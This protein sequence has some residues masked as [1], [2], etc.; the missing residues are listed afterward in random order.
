MRITKLSLAGASLFILGAVAAHGAAAQDTAKSTPSTAKS[1][2]TVVVVTGSRVIK[3]GD[4]SPSPVTVLPTAD[5][6]KVEPGA[7]LADALNSLPVFAGSRSAASNPTSVGSAAGGN[8]DANQLNLR[9]LGANRTLVLMDGMRVP[10]TLQ[11]AVVDVDIIPQMLVS[12]VDVVT[13]GVSAVYGSDAMSGVVNYVVN[14]KFNGF[15]ADAS[16]GITQYGDDV[17]T[18]GG[19]AWGHKIGDKGHLELSYE[20]HKED[21]VPYRTDRPWFDQ[22]GV[23]GS[24]AGSTVAPGSSGNPFEVF[25]NL[26]QSTS[27]FGGMITSG[28]LKGQTFTQNGVLS[29]FVAGAAT[30][31]TGVQV[32][33]GGAYANPNLLGAL[34][35]NQFFSR[36]DYDFSN[37]IHG[38]AEIASDVKTNV[39]E[40][41]TNQLT[42]VTLFSNNA[43]LSPTYQTAMAGSSTFTLSEYL[44]DVPRQQATAH[45]NQLIFTT[46]LDGKFGGAA[47]KIDYSHGDS[48]LRTDLVNII[49]NQHLALA[50]D[51]VQNPSSPTGTPV[52]YSTTISPG[53][54]CVAFNPF[55]PT[56][57]S[58][59]AINYITDTLHIGAETKMDDVSAQVTGSPFSTWAGPVN[60]ALSAEWRKTSYT[61]FS[62]ILPTAVVDCTT[63]GLRNNC[64]TATSTKAGTALGSVTNGQNLTPV[65]QTVAEIAGEFDAPLLTDSPLAKSLSINGAVRYTNYDTS[66]DYWTWKLGVDW[67]MSDALRFRATRS[68]DI[69]APTLYDLYSPPSVVPV[70]H[71]DYNITGNPSATVP[72]LTESNPNL[73][74]ELGNTWT[75]GFVWKPMPKLSFAIDGYDVKVSNAITQ[76]DGSTQAYQQ[77]CYNS[78]GSSPY[79]AL[80]IRPGPLTDHTAT[81]AVTEWIVEE[82]NIAEVETWGVDFETNY[83]TDLF[84]RPMTL[85]LLTDYQPHVYYRQPGTTTIDQGGVAFGPLGLGA[86]P[87]VRFDGFCHYQATQHFSIDLM[88]RWRN[89]MKLG[90]D[91][92]QYWVYNHIAA[93][94]TTGVT[95]NWDD[96]HRLQYY[97]NVQNL[98]NAAPPPGGYSGNSTRAGLRDG[99]AL[100]DDVRG[101]YYTVGIKLKM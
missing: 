29:P 56:A 19:I 10:P 64:V 43:F 4:N 62:S 17:T 94:G 58:Q 82:I 7:T 32:G 25:E 96:G 91:P 98:F 59:A 18:D 88:E 93:F 8:G 6:L 11:N 53:N 87:A 9:N 40:A 46:G 37:D 41:D 60:T 97:A 39:N 31:T 90:G 52:C 81:N 51:A 28:A 14:H 79:C 21:G 89:H 57:A 70:S 68:S 38:Y 36:F 34:H 33:G 95:L 27:T 1:D 54:G 99:Y 63:P 23:A 76:I 16:Y 71:I 67:Q 48:K 44:S 61:S 66:G 47:W 26:R 72:S 100:G 42:N 74:A 35:S 83:A 45:T 50:L 22:A 85:R 75:A 24:V 55:G 92:T 86:G 20:Y 12:R 2:E 30:G 15:R 84:G 49:N 69:R 80:Q 65:S 3:S 13:G 73:K 101:R 78:G 5:I 77:L